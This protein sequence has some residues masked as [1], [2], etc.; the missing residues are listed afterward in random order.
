[1]ESL[2]EAIPLA[3][4]AEVAALGKALDRATR[5]GLSA[6]VQALLTTGRRFAYIVAASGKATATIRMR[7]DDDLFV[8][9]YRTSE[10]PVHL[11]DVFATWTE[12]GAPG[13]QWTDYGDVRIERGRQGYARH[14]IAVTVD[15]EGAIVVKPGALRAHYAATADALWLRGDF[16][17]LK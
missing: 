14:E 17:A 16:L 9:R 4:T 12:K 2:V 11:Y 15:D 8:V 10:G 5:E 3:P 13:T 1:M 6:E 7:G